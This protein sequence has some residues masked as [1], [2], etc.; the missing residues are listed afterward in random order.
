MATHQPTDPEPEPEEPP[1]TP[2]RTLF[3]A[4]HGIW[5]AGQT[6]MP[7]VRAYLGGGQLTN[8]TWFGTTELKDAVRLST[9]AIW[10]SWKDD[11]PDALDR[12][13]ASKPANRV[14]IGTYHHEPEND[15]TGPAEVQR[16]Q[17]A[18]R[19]ALPIMRKHGVLS[20][21]CLLGH[22]SDAENEPFHVDG[23]DIT[24][25]DRYNPGLGNA[26]N[27][28]D[29]VQVFARCLAYG[30]KKRL[31]IAFGE[32][33]TIAIGSDA[34]GNGGDKAGRLAW[35]KKVRAHLAAQPDV[36]F[37]A[38]WSQSRM[39]LDDDLTNAWLG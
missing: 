38:W 12:L 6:A 26:K 34:N 1:T 21:T 24:G 35:T 15:G 10:L 27:Y 11:N 31:P 33:G 25:F 3:G 23:V 28:A 7:L 17:D 36:P 5:P 22:L 9:D 29:P 18:W 39:V 20:A 37:V 2:T 16:Y 4:T 14:V 13:L 32:T 19:R 8:A 30:R